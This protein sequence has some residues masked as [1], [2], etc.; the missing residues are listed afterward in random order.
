MPEVNIT[1]TDASALDIQQHLSDL[2]IAALL[3]LF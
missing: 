3:H 2:E 1:T